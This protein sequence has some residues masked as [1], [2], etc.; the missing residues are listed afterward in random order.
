MQ[1]NEQYP[2]GDNASQ[3]S[4]PQP[5]QPVQ[6][7]IV[8]P[9]GAQQSSADPLARFG[10]PVAPQGYQQPQS[11][12]PSGLPNVP[13]APGTVPAVVVPENHVPLWAWIVLGTLGALTIGGAVFGYWAFGERQ[14]YKN[15]TDQIVAREVE[16]AKSAQLETDNARFAEEAKMPLKPYKG[17]SAFGSISLMYPKTWSGYIDANSSGTTEFSALFHPNVVPA[18]GSRDAA[19]VA[20]TVEV[21]ATEYSDLMRQRE[22][23]VKNGELTATAYAFPKQTEQIGTRFVGKITN[24]LTG[25]EILVPL[26]DKTIVLTTQT[27]QYL[28][29]FNTNILPNFDF[30]P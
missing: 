13:G 23:R 29:D 28:A 6:P 9:G 3:P 1:P 12:Q 2:F 18:Q 16:T 8:V 19:A 7:G 5:Q 11:P 14:T 10:Q 25:T 30:Q 27:D 26:R 22:S 20:L 21:I 24:D 4:Q 15:D 17:P